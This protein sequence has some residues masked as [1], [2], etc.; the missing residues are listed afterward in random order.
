MVP[1]GRILTIYNDYPWIGD[2]RFGRMVVYLGGRRVGVI[3][4]GGGHIDLNVSTA[5][6][7]MIQ[8]RLWWWFRSR[9]IRAELRSGEHRVVRAD[10]DRSISVGTWMWRAILHPRQSLIIRDEVS[11]INPPLD[12]P[13]ARRRLVASAIVSAA[14]FG[15]VL[16]GATVTLLAVVI[17]GLAVAAVGLA[18]GVSQL[19]NRTRRRVE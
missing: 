13:T 16:V 4:C 8:V 12:V 1:P 19:A 2:P 15:L 6:A 10:L 7:H 14:G 18:I 9:P 11:R 5:E 3:E 17:A